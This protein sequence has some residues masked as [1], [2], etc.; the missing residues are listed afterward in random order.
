MGIVS[1]SMGMESG[2]KESVIMLLSSGIPIATVIGSGYSFKLGL[3]YMALGTTSATV[4][5]QIGYHF[6]KT[7]YELYQP[8]LK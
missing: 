4:F 6:T 8:F 3:G 7:V 1:A 2:S 5:Y